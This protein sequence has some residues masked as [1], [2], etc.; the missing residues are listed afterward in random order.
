MPTTANPAFN[1]LHEAIPG[2]LFPHA[3]YQGSTGPAVVTLQRKL[4]TQGCNADRLLIN[5][6]Y[7]AETRRGIEIFQGTEGLAVA[8]W[9][10]ADD[11]HNK[12]KERFGED[13]RELPDDP[14]GTPSVFAP[15]P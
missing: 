2:R 13:L 14:N 15:H 9:R 7:D 1:M 12:W 8:G 6:I 5:G 11:E 10:F 4:W 3:L